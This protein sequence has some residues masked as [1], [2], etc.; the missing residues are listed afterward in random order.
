MN[1][2]NLTKFYS[3]SRRL[4]Y[5][6]ASLQVKRSGLRSLI[7]YDDRFTT[8]AQHLERL[9]KSFNGEKLKILD[10]GV[11]DGIYE[12]ILSDCSLGEV[13]F[14]GVDIS[15]KQLV[16]SKKYL[17]DFKIVDLN[18]ENIPYGSGLFDIVI[19]SEI[20]EH[21]FYPEKVLNDSSRVL[22]NGGYLV[23]TY[24]NSGALQLRLS[25]FFTG[26]SPLLNYG[27]NKEHIRFFNKKDI[28]GMITSKV[29]ITHYQGLDSFLFG[30]WNFPIK[31]VTPRFLQV[32]GNRFLPGLA[33]GN[34]MIFK[35]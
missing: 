19:V 1:Q 12:N 2:L 28:L 29:K 8:V 16:R 13:E 26:H 24:P 21:V 33:L 23:L 25:L 11:G 14:Y 32:L 6:P 7:S 31:I 5:N 3:D 22:K 17:K 27:Q 9:I 18:K 34:F 4:A 15:E 35:K 20:L 10:I 30:K